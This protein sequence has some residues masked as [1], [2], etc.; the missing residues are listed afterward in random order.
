MELYTSVE[1][2]KLCAEVAKLRVERRQDAEVVPFHAHVEQTP[3]DAAGHA[4]VASARR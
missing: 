4:M 1:W 3:E 2:S